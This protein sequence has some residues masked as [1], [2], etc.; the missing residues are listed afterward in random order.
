MVRHI[1]LI[2]RHFGEDIDRFTFLF[3]VKIHIWSLPRYVC[4]CMVLNVF[5]YCSSSLW[6]SPSHPP[7]LW[8][9]RH[10]CFPS[11]LY[12][13]DS[14]SLLFCLI[15]LSSLSSFF[16]HYLSYLLLFVH[17]IS[18]NLYLLDLLYKLTVITGLDR[19]TVVK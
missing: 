19:L 2:F 11:H 7:L 18:Y 3:R 8:K 10:I 12:N 9:E 1:I 5:M 4:R 16:I 13:R 14:L 6:F 17:D 15:L